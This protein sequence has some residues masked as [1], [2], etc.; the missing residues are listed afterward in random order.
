MLATGETKMNVA[1]E[2]E[3]DRLVYTAEELLSSGEYKDPLIAN[4]GG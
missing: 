3:P 2:S 1:T 4:D